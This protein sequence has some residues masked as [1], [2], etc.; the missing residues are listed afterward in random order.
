MDFLY[1]FLIKTL[2][3]L[4]LIKTSAKESKKFF[5]S[6]LF[7]QIRLT[8]RKIAIKFIIKALKWFFSLIYPKGQGKRKSKQKEKGG[9]KPS[10]KRSEKITA[11]KEG[12]YYFF[13][14]FHLRKKRREK[15]KKRLGSNKFTSEPWKTCVVTG[16][17]NS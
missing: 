17:E 9:K 16:R 8:E 4:K 2:Q 15:N 12:G 11:G 5:F 3:I 6:S 14:F 7:L 1:V 10:S 13:L